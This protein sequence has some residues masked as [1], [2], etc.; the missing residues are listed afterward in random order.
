[1][2]LN[3]NDQKGF[4]LLGLESDHMLSLEKTKTCL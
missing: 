1:M 3:N 2:V 4:D